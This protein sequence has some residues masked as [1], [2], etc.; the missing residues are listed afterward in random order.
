MAVG[1]SKLLWRINKLKLLRFGEAGSE[2]PGILDVDD[3]I[4]DLSSI[5]DDISNDNL[6]DSNLEKLRNIDVNT[7]P[8]VDNNCPL[9]P[10]LVGKVN[11][12]LIVSEAGLDP[13]STMA[14]E[15]SFFSV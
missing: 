3:N 14:A 8:L 2:K 7:L 1:L 4:R 5:I 6:L 10:S 9:V 13:T 15:P 11:A 12:S